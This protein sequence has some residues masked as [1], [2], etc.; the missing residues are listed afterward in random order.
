MTTRTLILCGLLAIVSNLDTIAQNKFSIFT[1]TGYTNHLTRNGINMEIGFDYEIL[2]RLDITMAY[3]YNYMSRD[4]DHKVEINNTSLYL[5]WIILNR[6]SHR[7]LIGSGLY[8]GKYKR[9]SDY[10]FEKE[11]T[12]IWINPV[13]L[14]YDYTFSNNVR[15]GGI[16]SMY[17]DDGDG[18]SYF[19]F[20]LGY[21][22]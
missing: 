4:N 9:Y 1:S 17:G 13:R 18:T 7:F 16:V 3:R 20:L 22:F 21:K 14:L 6:N 10:S 2:K 11:Y 19:G 15:I 5:S 8:Y 12:Q